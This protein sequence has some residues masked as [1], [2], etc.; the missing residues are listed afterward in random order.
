MKDEKPK[1]SIFRSVMMLVAVIVVCGTIAFVIREVKET[2]KATNGAV[3]EG[4][5]F[6]RDVTG[7]SEEAKQEEEFWKWN[8]KNQ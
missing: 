6:L 5:D 4:F 1:K 8:P 7:N 3:H 2:A